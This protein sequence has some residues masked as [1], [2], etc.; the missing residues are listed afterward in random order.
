MDDIENL[1]TSLHTPSFLK[2]KDISFV[3]E[4]LAY[5]LSSEKEYLKKY[6]DLKKKYKICPNKPTLR[7]VYLYLL[8]EKKI[9]ENSNFL[10]FTIKRNVVQILGE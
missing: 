6:N 1:F 2:N 8:N 10:N 4:L 9:Q 7:K 5:P 3:K